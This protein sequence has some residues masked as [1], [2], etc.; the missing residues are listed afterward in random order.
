MGEWGKLKLKLTQVELEAWAELGKRKHMREDVSLIGL[1]Q[2]IH[3]IRD[4]IYTDGKIITL[5]HQIGKFLQLEDF[6]H[7]ET[8]I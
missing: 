2:R 6:L 4:L 7:T 8:N 5:N 1:S 3:C